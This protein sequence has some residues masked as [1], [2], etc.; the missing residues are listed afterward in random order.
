MSAGVQC[1]NCRVFAP[2]NPAGWL[3]LIQQPAEETDVPL[4]VRALFGTPSEPLTFCTVKCVAEYT[5]A[6]SVAAEASAG[7]EPG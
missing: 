2:R 7:T 4:V 3:Y 1:D 5:F 6:Q